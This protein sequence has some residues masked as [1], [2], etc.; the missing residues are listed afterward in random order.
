M[1]ASYQDDN[2]LVLLIPLKERCSGNRADLGLRLR[3]GQRQRQSFTLL[4][5]VSGVSW[6]TTVSSLFV[7]QR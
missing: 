5:R 7:G 6:K 2:N 1:G 3:S 4:L